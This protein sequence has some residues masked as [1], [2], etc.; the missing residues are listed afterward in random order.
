MTSSKHRYF[1]THRQLTGTPYI[2]HAYVYDDNKVVMACT[3]RH[4]E[5]TPH[6]GGVTAQACAAIA[7]RNAVFK[8]VPRSYVN[9]LVERAKEVA[10]GTASQVIVPSGLRFVT[11]K[12]R[13]ASATVKSFLA[14]IVLPNLSIIFSMIAA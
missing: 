12:E 9:R 8:V 6:R 3:H 11:M 1:A 2:H 7:G 4:G 13:I 5:R 14:T 10:R